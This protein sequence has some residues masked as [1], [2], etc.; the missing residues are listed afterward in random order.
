MLSHYRYKNIVAVGVDLLFDIQM[1]YPCQNQS[2]QRNYENCRS[3][4]PVVPGV[5]SV[6]P[7]HSNR[8]RVQYRAPPLL[9]TAPACLPAYETTGP[10]FMRHP[11]HRTTAPPHHCAKPHRPH[12]RDITL[13]GV[14]AKDAW[15]SMWINCLPESPCEGLAFKNVQVGNNTL[16]AVC[17]HVSGE[18]TGG[19]MFPSAECPL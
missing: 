4:Y 2:G 17:E 12:I 15:R 19:N 7:T 1:W 9:S 6:A 11:H 5:R 13:D 10:V 8:S 14:V 3:Y 18:A 16:G